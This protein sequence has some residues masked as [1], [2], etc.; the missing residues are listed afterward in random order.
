MSSYTPGGGGG[1]TP[2]LNSPGAPPESQVSGVWLPPGSSCSSHLRNRGGHAECQVEPQAGPLRN[3][4]SYCCPTLDKQFNDLI[5]AP[6]QSLKG[7][8]R[9]QRGQT[10]ERSSHFDFKQLIIDSQV[11]KTRIVPSFS[12]YDFSNELPAGSRSGFAAHTVA[13]LSNICLSPSSSLTELQ[14][15]PQPG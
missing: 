7:R 1:S 9:R 6:G 13:C 2:C 4:T 10:E 14:L 12:Y 11:E 3:S 15:C 5:V 8:A